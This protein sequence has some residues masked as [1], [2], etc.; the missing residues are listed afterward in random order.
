MVRINSKGDSSQG[1]VFSG[2]K[3]FYKNRYHAATSGL[4]LFDSEIPGLLRSLYFHNTLMERSIFGVKNADVTRDGQIIIVDDMG[5]VY[6]GNL[7][8]YTLFSDPYFDNVSD[9][10]SW[11]VDYMVKVKVSRLCGILPAKSAFLTPDGRNK[12]LN[13][14]EVDPRSVLHCTE[15]VSKVEVS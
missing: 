15:N 7:A 11:I 2:F 8:H 10:F 1:A 14:L 13:L 9:G 6:E 4:F 3:Y 12:V 5:D